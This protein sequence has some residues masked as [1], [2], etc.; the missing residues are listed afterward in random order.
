MFKYV[1]T[2]R[3]AAFR[4][5]SKTFGT[6]RKD[7]GEG[8]ID[9][10]PLRDLVHLLGFEDLNEAK[11]ACAHY[12]IAVKEMPL[13]NGSVDHIDTIFGGPVQD[14]KNREIHKRAPFFR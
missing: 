10:Y 11:N 12:N 14:L 9:Q 4:I 1:E 6:K 5:M 3:R 7:S 8:I 2:M 13:G